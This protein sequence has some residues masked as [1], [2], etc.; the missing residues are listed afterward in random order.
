MSVLFKH[1]FDHVVARQHHGPTT[2][3]NLAFCCVDCNRHKGP[4][5]SGIDPIGKRVVELFNPRRDVWLEHFCWNGAVLQGLTAQGRATIDVLKINLPKRVIT[6]RNLIT[7][8][9]F[10]IQT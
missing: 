9:T 3:T 5:L 1:V 10:F 4:N 6:R 7:A 8:G 2:A